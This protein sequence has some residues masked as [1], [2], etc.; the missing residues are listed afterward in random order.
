MPGS[1]VLIPLQQPLLPRPRAALTRSDHEE[2][3]PHGIT[4]T[5]L[6]PG[7]VRTEFQ[8]LAGIKSDR[9]RGRVV[10]RYMA[11][12][13]AVEVVAAAIEA[14]EAGKA[15]VIPGAVNRAI[16]ET[17]QALPRCVVRRMAGAAFEGQARRERP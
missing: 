6:C 13:S 14:M 5:C 1:D 8:H 17:A 9:M 16:V 4:V 15:V 10:L 3:K 7:P 12:T 11:G 2:A